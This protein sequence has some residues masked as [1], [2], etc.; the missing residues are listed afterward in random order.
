MT[1]PGSILNGPDL[2]PD[3]AFVQNGNSFGAIAT[4]GT[5]DAFR[6]DFETSGT[7]KMTLT[8]GGALVIG[9]TAPVGAELLRVVGAA[10]IEGK[11][12]VTG[13][14]DP[15]S[16]LLS[17][18]TALFF[19]SNDG[20]TAPVSGAATGRLRYNNAGTGNWQ[21]SMQGI[22]YVNILTSAS[23]T[24]F[25]QGGNSFAATGTLGTNDAFDLV[26]R[27]A[28]VDRFTLTAGAT[29]G[30]LRG[31]SGTAAAP[32]YSFSSTTTAG[33]FS[34]AADMV[35]ISTLST[36]VLRVNDSQQVLIGATTAIGTEKLRVTG[37]VVFF[38]FTSLTAFEV[39]Q[40]GGGTPALVVD[41]TNTR[42]GI[43][44]APGAFTLDINGNTRIRV[45]G[46]VL[47]LIM[48][49]GTGFSTAPGTA[50]VDTAQVAN[51]TT[52]ETTLSTYTLLANSL[53]A[54]GKGIFYYHWGTINGTAGTKTIRGY[55]GATVVISRAISATSAG[56]YLM[57]VRVFRTG[58]TAQIA[59]GIVWMNDT[60]SADFGTPT[61]STP[62][63]TLSGNV[64]IKVTGQNSANNAGLVGKGMDIGMIN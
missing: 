5:N 54:N 36:E 2:G 33:I 21:V 27:T 39:T 7:T 30:R 43:G 10:R 55:F 16:V 40:T 4:L 29:P 63:E 56:D 46:S 41:T 42:V 11:L 60:L 38:D 64:T 28:G 62:A 59:V 61:V 51:S 49:T 57:A 26:L 1:I 9:G 3:T 50:N 13:A 58:A 22:A 18:G 45:G 32:T 44:A 6:L 47:S 20:V 12:T 14:I 19:E 24:F 53:S 17:G 52:T 34:P 48:G 25:A 15:P 37:N 23:G 8:T 35:A 31:P